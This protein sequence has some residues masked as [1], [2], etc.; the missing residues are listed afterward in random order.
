MPKIK[1]RNVPLILPI[2]AVLAGAIVA[3]KP[4]YSA[5]GNCGIINFAPSVI[6]ISSIKSHYTN[7]GIRE[8]GVFSVNIPSADWFG[9][10]TTAAWYP[11]ARPTKPACSILS[12]GRSQKLRCLPSARST[13]PA[14]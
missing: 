5:I 1:V 8:N 2:P 3:G 7:R 4:N 9:R 14:G 11:A 10:S 12:T 13:W 6:Y